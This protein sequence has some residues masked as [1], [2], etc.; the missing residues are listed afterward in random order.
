MTLEEFLLSPYWEMKP[1]DVMPIT[2]NWCTYCE[3]PDLYM[4]ARLEADSPSGALSGAQTKTTAHKVYV[5]CCA[6]C[7]RYSGDRR[8]S[9]DGA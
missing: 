2:E 3:S 5:L 6:V 1:G 9:P 7:G 4:E 8:S